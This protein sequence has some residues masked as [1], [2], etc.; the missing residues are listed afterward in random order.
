M[1]KTRITNRAALTLV[2]LLVTITIM[3]IVVAV[4]IPAVK[5]MLASNKVKNGASIV[6]TYL[7]QARARAMEEGR[8]VGVRFER[9]TGIKE[10]NDYPYN[11]ASLV[12]RQVA[13]PKPY[14]GSVKDVH[15]IIDFNPSTKIGIIKFCGWNGANWNDPSVHNAESAYWDKLV[16][17]GDLLQCAFKGPKYTITKNGVTFY[18]DMKRDP[19]NDDLIPNKNPNYGLPEPDFSNTDNPVRFRVYRQPQPN[20]I[21]PTMA[22]PVALPQGV[23]VDLDCS[24]I[25]ASNDKPY[26]DEEGNTIR[27][28]T[29]NLNR[30]TVIRDDFTSK[31]P[32]DDSAVTVMFSPTGDVD[33]VYYQN[34]EDNQSSGKI[35]PEPIFL[36]IGV[37]ERIGCWVNGKN[38]NDYLPNEADPSRNYQDLN[39]YWVTI[40]PRN[41]LVRTNRV[42]IWGGSTG[43]KAQL[44]SYKN[45][46]E[47]A[48]NLLDEEVK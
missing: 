14:S 4:S 15:A 13:E 30:L 21:A 42:H 43:E 2:E 29:H 36:C 22:A 35:P 33:K 37:W 11:G 39:N 12:M 31:A 1:R 6:S 25:G 17:S 7:T 24:G 18:I 10:G 45:S 34:K 41:G 8:T 28:E 16:N 44:T 9:Y 19:L 27:S 23:V 3:A 38:S 32:D 40:F 5:P 47:F 46:R 26:Y 48:Q 20:K